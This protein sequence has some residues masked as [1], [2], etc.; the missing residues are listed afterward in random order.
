MKNTL[1]AIVSLISFGMYAQE[2]NA[3]SKPSTDDYDFKCKSMEI[4][5]DNKTITLNEDASYKDSIIEITGA[6]QIVFD[7]ANN[8][9]IAT[10]DYSF[11]IDGSVEFNSKNDDKRLR[12]KIGEAVA[13]IE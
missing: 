5:K 1:L 10:G 9:V 4:D 6:E 3:V 13:Y 2:E 8:E 12:Y 11:T 7:Q